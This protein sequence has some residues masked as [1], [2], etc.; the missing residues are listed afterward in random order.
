MAD[1]AVIAE[2]AKT[3]SVSKMPIYQ[4]DLTAMQNTFTN[5]L[6][7][8]GSNVADAQ[9]ISKENAQQMY[10]ELTKGQDVTKPNVTLPK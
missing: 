2:A 4:A 9:T 10:A 1:K 5:V 6:K 7:E 8:I 3:I